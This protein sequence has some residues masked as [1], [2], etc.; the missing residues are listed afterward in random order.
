MISLPSPPTPDILAL[1]AYA[2]KCDNLCSSA[3]ST[4]YETIVGY[5][6]AT[7]T[8]MGDAI[9]TL[10]S[11]L[12]KYISR[13]QS[14]ITRIQNKLYDSLN[15]YIANAEHVV[16]ES[17]KLLGI[18][19]AIDAS[20][21]LPSVAP[22][23]SPQNPT[24]IA[25]S[26]GP[27]IQPPPPLPP[28]PVCPPGQKPLWIINPITGQGTWICV[29]D[30]GGG[31]GDGSGGGG[32]GGLALDCACI[33]QNVNSLIGWLAAQFE[34]ISTCKSGPDPCG[35]L[36]PVPYP[37]SPYKWNNPEGNSWNAISVAQR[38][39]SFIEYNFAPPHSEYGKQ[40]IEEL[41]PDV[42]NAQQWVQFY[43]ENT[44]YAVIHNTIY[45]ASQ[46]S[47]FGDYDG[48]KS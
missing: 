22:S 18:E 45:S 39:W 15:V 10:L 42:F 29:D 13:S 17:N 12:S 26:S 14:A 7:H 23:E 47:D 8:I 4:I 43:T 46:G 25:P 30:S 34:L 31:S 44:A 1:D 3:I 27:E 19:P 36:T 9:S 5:E 48:S 40:I 41:I 11:S 28:P 37:A 16:N 32:G 6:M 35:P 24:Q 38:K 2:D 33:I 21:F 20:L